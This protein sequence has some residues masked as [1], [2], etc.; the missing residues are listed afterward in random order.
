M[1]D[2]TR[3]GLSAVLNEIA[4]MSKLAII[5]YETSIKVVS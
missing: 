1:M 4:E 2:A 5:L 3:G